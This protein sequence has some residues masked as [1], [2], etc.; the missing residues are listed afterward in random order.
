[1]K[2]LKVSLFILVFSFLLPVK[3][4]AWIPFGPIK[5]KW[6]TLFESACNTKKNK[7]QARL[8]TLTTQKED[9]METYARLKDRL[10]Q[11]IDDWEELGYDVDQLNEDLEALGGK[12]Q[13][14]SEKVSMYLQKLSDLKELACEDADDYADALGETR[15][16]LG[17]VRQAARD[18][19]QF[20]QNTIRP[21]ILALRDQIPSPE[22]E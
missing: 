17:D 4:F 16:A 6:E 10:A 18:I 21:H 11:K 15:D 8:D 3:A 22:G 20:Y 7:V 12:V 19:R 9:H 2:K 14:Y 13:M 1:M 5:G